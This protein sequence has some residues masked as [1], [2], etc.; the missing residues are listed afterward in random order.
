LARQANAGLL[1]KAFSTSL[2]AMKAV[3]V[4]EA[5]LLDYLGGAGVA[6]GVGHLSRYEPQK[7]LPLWY[8]D[9]GRGSVRLM[10][11]KSTG[12]RRNGPG[13]NAV[14]SKHR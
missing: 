2:Y 5:E 10:R 12:T 1:P 6:A 4:L 3:V 13:R 8:S 7:T 9:A 14:R 11:G